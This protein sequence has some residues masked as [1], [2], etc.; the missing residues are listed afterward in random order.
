MPE[1]DGHW[2]I[3]AVR[4]LPPADGGAI[5]AV[6]LTAWTAPKDREEAIAAGYNRHLGKPV[7]PSALVAALSA[8]IARTRA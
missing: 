8:L 3:R 7:D 5:S 6:A 2:L 4:S 1:Q